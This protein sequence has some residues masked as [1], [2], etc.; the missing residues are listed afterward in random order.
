[1]RRRLT[2]ALAV[3]LALPAA[4]LG[5]AGPATAEALV[6]RPSM[7]YEAE[8]GTAGGYSVALRTRGQHVELDIELAR[9]YGRRATGSFIAAYSTEGRVGEHGIHAF[10][11]ALGAVDL[12]FFPRPDQASPAPPAVG[13]ILPPPPGPSPGPVA[14]SCRG[15]RAV[16][17]GGWLRGTVAF[18]GAE[19]WVR[20]RRSSARASFRRTFRRVCDRRRTGNPVPDP[21]GWPDAGDAYVVVAL[22]HDGSRR[23]FLREEAHTYENGHEKG[24]AS[25][26]AGFIE[27]HDGVSL[28]EHLWLDARTR[29][30]VRESGDRRRVTVSPPTPFAG[31]AAYTRART[32]RALW[33]GPLAVSLPGAPEIALSGPAY[34]SDLCG[35]G[36]L[37]RCEEEFSAGTTA[38][39]PKPR[40]TGGGDARLFPIHYRG[41]ERGSGDS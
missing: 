7:Q 33:R 8:L 14:P 4:G 40:A 2:I 31:G 19:D 38:A 27:R 36:A 29:F 3:S 10:F 24:A 35:G 39:M 22:G 6:T 32:G 12:R 17:R 1:M 34:F 20:F 15:R 9:S 26:D 23:T 41:R 25:L 13:R 28:L 30:H 21:E 11:G 5:A 16:E 18:E 37:A